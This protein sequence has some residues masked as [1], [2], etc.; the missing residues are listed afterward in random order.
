MVQ[1]GCPLVTSSTACATASSEMRFFRRSTV[2]LD[3]HIPTLLNMVIAREP[4][5]F[6][7]RNSPIMS[8][9]TFVA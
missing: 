4:V 7:F 6:T 1:K 2:Q 9:K 5:P 8:G 3:T